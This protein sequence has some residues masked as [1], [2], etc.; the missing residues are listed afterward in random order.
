[1]TLKL[2]SHNDKSFV[3]NAVKSPVL[4]W[5]D[6]DLLMKSLSW[7]EITEDKDYEEF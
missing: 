7:K 4:V 1:M 2:T 3:L 5:A 6:V